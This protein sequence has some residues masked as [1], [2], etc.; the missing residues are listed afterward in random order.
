[1]ALRCV[2]HS[3]PF[4]I[5]SARYFSQSSIRMS[6]GAACKHFS[7]DR[8]QRTSTCGPRCLRT[9]A[10]FSIP[11]ELGNHFA[12]GAYAPVTVIGNLWRRL[13]DK[14]LSAPASGLTELERLR[15]LLMTNSKRTLPMFRT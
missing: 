1:M 5:H 7:F 4:S 2:I 6:P 14:R 12:S 13:Q 8:Q 11:E 3:P 10:R 15:M 9:H